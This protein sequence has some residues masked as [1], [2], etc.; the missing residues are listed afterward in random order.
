M[1]AQCWLHIGTE[2]TGTTTIRAFLARNRLR[3][4]SQ[5][6]LYPITPGA[7][8]H[9]GLTAFSRDDAENDSTRRAL[10][11]G[12]TDSLTD[13]RR[14]FTAALETEIATSGAS[15][16][17][18][19]NE[20][21]SSRL[22]RPSE[23]ARIKELCDKIARKTVVVVYLRNQVDFLV[24]RYTNVVAEGGTDAFR[25]ASGSRLADYSA[26]LDRWRATFGR[27]NLLVRRF[28]RTDFPQGDLLADFAAAMGLEHEKLDRVPLQNESLDVESLV[29]LRALNRF[30]PAF[31]ARHIVPLRSRVATL[32]RRHR[33]G[34]KFLIPRPLA[35]QIENAFRDSNERVCADYFQSRRPLF[36]PPA[37]VEPLDR[38][39]PTPSLKIGDTLRIM[40][41][42]ASGLLGELFRRDHLE[43]RLRPGA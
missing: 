42:L 23:L 30:A 40:G 41:F 29:F 27:E 16:L 7:T 2:K 3:L 12:D 36:S 6:C 8:N 22:R 25:F 11:I 21:L 9:F 19:S 34:T 14:E 35:E 39:A 33:G 15:V 13:F 43:P 31:L 17:I 37:L 18:L 24:S 28:E 32:L 4:L 26:L 1:I 10:G 38:P 20:L 5:A